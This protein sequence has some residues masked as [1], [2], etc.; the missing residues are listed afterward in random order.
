MLISCT[1]TISNKAA[2]LYGIVP[3][4]VVQIESCVIDIEKHRVYNVTIQRIYDW[5]MTTCLHEK[6]TIKS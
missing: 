4:R 3:I 2:L 6:M 5:L 1:T